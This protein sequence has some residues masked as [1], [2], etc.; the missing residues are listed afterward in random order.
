MRQAIVRALTRLP[1][2]RSVVTFHV[3]ALFCRNLGV[4]LGSGMTLSSALRILVDM[5]GGTGHPAVW[6]HVVGRVRQGS[7]LSDALA[8]VHA[9]PA[10]AVRMLKLVSPLLALTQVGM[11]REE[12]YR[13]VQK[14]AMRA[15]NGQQSLIDLLRKDPDVARVLDA[16]ALDSLFTY[17]H[18]L[19]HVDTIF[20]RVFG[21]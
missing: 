10:M 14:Y 21:G 13:L 17:D 18:H 4:L 6:S 12:A 19:K 2:V 8:E 9:L 16:R 7:K 5:M 15:W 1:L 20:A 11:T 3:T